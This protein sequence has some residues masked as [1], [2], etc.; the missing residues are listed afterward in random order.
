MKEGTMYRVMIFL[1]TCKKISIFAFL[2]LFA[3]LLTKPVLAVNIKKT[4][5]LSVFS[6]QPLVD[7]NKLMGI[8]FSPTTG[9]WYDEAG[10]EVSNIFVFPNP[11]TADQYKFHFLVD[12]EKAACKLTNDDQFDLI[13]NIEDISTPSGKNEQFFCYLPGETVTLENI[14]FGLDD[15]ENVQIRWYEDPTGG[16]PLPLDTEIEDGRTYYASQV[17]SGKGES[18]DRLSVTVGVGITP[19]LEIQQPLEANLSYDLSELVFDDLNNSGG[20][21]DY[22]SIFPDT[23]DYN[24]GLITDYLLQQTQDVYVLMSTPIGCYDIDKVQI[25]IQQNLIIPNGFSPNGD[26]I[27]DYF[28]IPGIHHY[29]D[30]ELIIFNRWEKIVYQ[31]KNYQNDW[32]GKAEKGII[33]DKE[34]LPEGTYFYVLKLS[35]DS[36]VLKGFIYLKH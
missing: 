4:V 11:H 34:I 24:N 12:N 8:A 25:N 22:Y 5:E 27:N 17:Y 6:S 28:V 26:G 32:G 20:K 15:V 35:K 3:S 7:L 21:V 29:P 31:S 14:Q 2:M 10:N 19:D 33:L 16:R 23:S 13:I 18:L 36:P 9:Q 1:K 30:N